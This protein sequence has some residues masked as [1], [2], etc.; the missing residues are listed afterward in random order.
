MMI[1]GRKLPSV[2][3]FLL[4]IEEERKRLKL[5]APGPPSAPQNK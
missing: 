3:V 2:N 5:T 4:A 1:N